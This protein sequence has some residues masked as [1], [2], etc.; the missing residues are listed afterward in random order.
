[1]LKVQVA[2]QD[3]DGLVRTLGYGYG[4]YIGSITGGHPVIYHTGDNVGFQSI[5]AW[6]PEDAVRLIVLT[7]EETTDLRVI[8]GEMVMM[9]FP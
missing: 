4:W 5:N 6:F 7:N 9:A 3:D 2:V 8:M 1:M